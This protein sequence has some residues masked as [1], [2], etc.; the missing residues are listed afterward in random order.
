LA[1]SVGSQTI[2]ATP[3]QAASALLA[4]LES[5]DYPLFLSVAGPQMARFWSADDP[6][7]DDL[8][9]DLFVVAA[10]RNGIQADVAAEDR[11]LLYAGRKEE[12]F[13]A[14]LVKTPYGWRF[15]GETG[16][17][18]VE[19]RRM[20][21]NEV[22]VIELC[23][24]FREAEY[25]YFGM[26]PGGVRVFA[27]KIRSTPGQHD[28]LFWS[29]PGGEDESPVGPAFAA[30]AYA[31]RHPADDT[32]PLFGYYFKILPA[33]GPDASGGALDYRKD[34]RLRKGFA[35]VAWPAEYG[36]AGTLSFLINHFGDI[37]QKDLGADTAQVAAD[38]TAFN[39]DRSWT[40]LN[41]LE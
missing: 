35:L 8:Y 11:R 20:R 33:Q 22:A 23:Q 4:A 37:Y 6:D 24:R 28:G 32:R 16:S 3:D 41:A 30:A 7:K 19:K 15:D 1:A 39:P 34:G 2:F 10:R 29:G 12:P 13:P 38:M 9:R 18:E 36:V 5:D 17:R 25:A 21:R 26:A 40:R 31:E 27:M 14:P